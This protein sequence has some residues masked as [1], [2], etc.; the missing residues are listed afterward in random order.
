MTVT[1]VVE[2]HCNLTTVS[3]SQSLIVIEKSFRG[4]SMFFKFLANL[5]QLAPTGIIQSDI[6]F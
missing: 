4:F 2:N 3:Q 1:V 6:H 5:A